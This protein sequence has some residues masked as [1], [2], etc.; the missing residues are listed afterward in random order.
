MNSTSICITVTAWLGK[1]RWHDAVVV[2]WIVQCDSVLCYLFVSK[3]N[4]D[5][6][7]IVSHD[8]FYN[9]KK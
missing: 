6:N 2:F 1:C 7:Q 4:W 8:A 5:I 9:N 3:I